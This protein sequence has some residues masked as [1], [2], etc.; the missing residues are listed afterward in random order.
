MADKKMSSKI[1][2]FYIILLFCD[3]TSVNAKIIY[4]DDYISEMHQLDLIMYPLAVTMIKQSI[5][6]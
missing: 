4:V 1:L 6:V 2:Y 5:Q 3:V